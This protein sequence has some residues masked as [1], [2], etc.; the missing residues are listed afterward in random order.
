MPDDRALSVRRALA[1][2]GAGPSGP[3][4]EAARAEG[5]EA[6]LR[7]AVEAVSALD[8][9]IEALSAELDD[10]AR[11]YE[12]AVGVEHA[13]LAEAE[14]V[15]RR[16]RSLEE[17]LLGLA[18]RVRAGEREPRPATGRRRATRSSARRPTA[19]RHAGEPGEDRGRPEPARPGGEAAPAEAQQPE[20]EPQAVRLKRVYRRLARLLHPDLAQDDSERAR[21]GD[22]MARVNAAY[23]KGDLTALE[24]MAEKLGAG[25]PPGDVSPAERVAHLERRTATM[26]RFAASLTRE[27]DRLRRSDTYRLR[28][29]ATRRAGE[30]GDLLEETRAELAEEIAAAWADVL[31]RLGRLS[32]AARDVARARTEAMAEIQRRGPTGARRAFDPLRENDIVRAGAQRLD[33]RRATTAA[34]DLARRLEEQAAKAPWDVA[35][36]VLAFLAEDAGA[37]P[38]EALAGAEGW[39]AAWDRMR[40]EWPESP[41]LA[42]MLARLPRGLAL[43]ART[44]GEDVQAGVQLE[45]AELAAGVRIAL[46]G[47]A[48]AGIG[49]RVLA[50]L[51]PTETCPSCRERGPA[52]HLLRTRGLDERHGLACASCGTILRSYWRYGEVDGLEALAE[53]ALRLGLVAEVTADLGG[54]S[55]G[56]QMLPPERE[57]L[58]AAQLRRRFGELYL[59]AYEIGLEPA[60]IRVEGPAGPVGPSARV[61]ALEDLRFAPESGSAVPNAEELLELLR[62]RIERRFRP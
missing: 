34:R 27:R 42:R 18:A 40:E 55:I 51:G 29:E 24:V 47:E 62:A 38:P 33:R 25:D 31:A 2:S 45:D 37:R 19:W 44:Q 52:R 15:V 21:L 59:A 49:R 46:E 14:R 54:T 26:E 22:L 41:D 50:A 61:G 58:T 43:G 39:A 6:R 57:S 35:L 36:I 5:A 53:H 30:G 28:V 7:A 8:L 10:F 48:V 17:A 12:R 11:R 9:E 23:A 20:V 56:F 3:R 32:R 1:R 16:L 60:E 13:E 4:E